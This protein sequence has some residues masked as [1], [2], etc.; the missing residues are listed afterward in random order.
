MTS[1]NFS[2]FTPDA[3]APAQTPEPSHTVGLPQDDSRFNPH[4]APALPAEPSFTHP[5]S[6]FHPQNSEPNPPAPSQM[7]A[8]QRDF[9]ALQ[10]EQRHHIDRV[11]QR[12]QS[13]YA[14]FEAAADLR[15]LKGR[16]RAQAF[17]VLTIW[18]VWT[19]FVTLMST[20]L[21]QM[22]NT[23]ITFGAFGILMIPATI[24]A[25][26]TLIGVNRKFHASVAALSERLAQQDERHP[27]FE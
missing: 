3:T 22:T 4:G 1:S 13:T 16:T 7:N 21:A 6:A 8:A 25:I 26:W 10:S 17:G 5:Q 12:D 24:A 2:R 19:A 11:Q 23:H 14:R 20:G 9:I 27:A 18:A 15:S